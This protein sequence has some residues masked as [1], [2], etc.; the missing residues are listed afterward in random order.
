MLFHYPPF[1][2][3]VYVYV[4]HRDVHLLEEFSVLVGKG[5]REVFKERVLG[6]DLPPVARVR[7]LYIRKLVL[8][9]ESSLSQY[10]VNETLLNMMD[11]YCSHPRYKGIQM[12]YD[13]DPM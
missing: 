3:L 7:Q 6:P 10:K 13:V 9:V 8:K 5:L 11:S 12:Y 4:K 2:R 1:Y